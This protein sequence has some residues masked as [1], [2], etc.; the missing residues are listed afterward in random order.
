ME[1]GG[2]DQYYEVEKILKCKM[3]N[4]KRQYL[5]KWK[6]FPSSSNS[7]E[8]E[9]NLT[10]DLVADYHQRISESKKSAS[11]KRSA[12]LII[13]TG[14][15]RRRIVSS[16]GGGES[17]NVEDSN[18]VHDNVTPQASEQE[19]AAFRDNYPNEAIAI[20]GAVKIGGLLFH[21]VRWKDNGHDELIPAKYTNYLWPQLVIAFYSKHLHIIDP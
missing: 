10:Q 20:N 14:P 21:K 4:G 16:A 6:N 3:K 17:S 18:Y 7:W 2:D 12:S 1:G 11:V 9:E 5:I 13:P 19:I 15:H 8:P